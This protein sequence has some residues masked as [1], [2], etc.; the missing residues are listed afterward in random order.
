S[1]KKFQNGEFSSSPSSNSENMK[2][3]R[4]NIISELLSTE[5][6][7]VSDLESVLL[8]YRDKLRCGANPAAIG[9][10]FSAVCQD[11]KTLYCAYCQNMPSARQAV[12]ELG[13]ESPP[14]VLY[15]CMSEAGHQL[16]LSSYLLKPMQRLTKYQLML[17]D[18]LESSNVVCGKEDLDSALTC[19]LG[20][21]KVVND[22]LNEVNIKG[23][24]KALCP[25]GS[26]VASDVFQVTSENKSQSQILFRNRSQRR[27]VFLHDNQLLVCKPVN[28]KTQN[29]QFKFS[30]ATSSLGMSSIVKGEDKKIELWMHGR[31]ELYSLEAKTKKAK[32]DFAAELRRVIIRQKEQRSGSSLKPQIYYDT[33]SSSTTNTTNSSGGE[34]GCL[35]SRLTRSRSLESSRVSNTMRSRSLDYAGDRS[36]DEEDEEGRRR[37][38][39]RYLVLADY[40]AL[41]SRE[42]DL[43]EDDSVELIKVGC[44]GWWYVRLTVYP[45]PEG[46]APSTYLEKILD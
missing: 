18:L 41:T 27:T 15:Q 17:R 34:S 4:E 33:A 22:S 1:E 20:V 35:D 29:Y 23:L 32:E 16:P 43:S 10:T 40:M 6:R 42:I 21:I 28:E 12:A 7:Y 24:P 36:S 45:Y 14:S 9:R 8:N 5:S 11:L 30:L 37:H 31:G 25:L 2:T 19:L 39:G 13:G 26:L 44:A 38:K 3:R 46:W